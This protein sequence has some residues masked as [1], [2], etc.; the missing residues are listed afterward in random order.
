MKLISLT[1]SYSLYC[2]GRNNSEF[3]SSLLV[4]MLLIRHAVGQLGIG[5]TTDMGIPTLVSFFDDLGLYVGQIKTGDSHTIALTCT[6][7]SV[8]TVLHF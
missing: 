2:W 5:N 3:S 4:M 1:E 8:L 7:L 6:F